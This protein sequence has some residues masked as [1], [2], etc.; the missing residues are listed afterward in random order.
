[1]EFLQQGLLGVMQ[2]PGQAALAVTATQARRTGLRGVN[3]ETHH[4]A[5]HVHRAD[6]RVSQ[7]AVQP[8]PR[9]QPG[10]V[11]GSHFSP[12]PACRKTVIGIL[13]DCH[14]R[15]ARGPDALEYGHSDDRRAGP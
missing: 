2:I 5:G 14:R 11:S 7:A 9:G 6:R 12:F 13:S 1:M 8:L 3:A 4:A 15:A 10:V